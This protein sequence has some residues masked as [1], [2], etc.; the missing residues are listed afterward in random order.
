MGSKVTHLWKGGAQPLFHGKYKEC[1][2]ESQ[3]KRNINIYMT[4]MTEGDISGTGIKGI[5]RPLFFSETSPDT[6]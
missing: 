1:F 3:E 5:L 4:F 6:F 2:P